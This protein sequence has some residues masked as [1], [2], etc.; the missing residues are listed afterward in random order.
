MASPIYDACPG[1][2]TRRGLDWCPG[3]LSE[4]DLG[5]SFH[6]PAKD[7][8]EAARLLPM[9]EAALSMAK[10]QFAHN[11]WANESLL[12]FLQTMP[13]EQY[14]KTPCSG[15]GPI[16]ATVAHL[17]LVHQS[18]L[19]W[20]SGSLPLKEAFAL[21]SQ[22]ASLGTAAAALERWQRVNEITDDFIEGLTPEDFVTE[23]PFVTPGG[24][25]SSLPLWEMLLQVTSHGV[26]TRG[27][28][29]SA[30]RS[31]GTKPVEVSFLQFCLKTKQDSVVEDEPPVE[32]VV[33]GSENL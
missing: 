7:S 18:W 31:T 26:H 23:R 25:S 29:V 24:F 33:E 30:I 4:R 20:L 21:P 17:V 8:R 19:E 3:A 22:T 16:G 9:I 1:P 10:V 13:A 28:I 2:S 15:N 11:N 14:E 5:R 12:N 32:G 6:I 27:Q